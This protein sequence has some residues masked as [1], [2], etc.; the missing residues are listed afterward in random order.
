MK[1]LIPIYVI[2][3]RNADRRTRMRQ[4]F[5]HF[6]I[7]PIFTPEVTSEDPRLAKAPASSKRVW[8][9]MLQHMDSIQ[10]FYDCGDRL[11]HCII[12]EDDIHISNTFP[13]DMDELIPKFDEM[14]L[15]CLLLGCL[16]NFKL[17][18][19]TCLHREHFAIAGNTLKFNLHRYPGDTWGCQ[20]YMISRA[21]AKKM[22][23]LYTIDYALA[24]MDND[25]YSP[26]WTLTKG[27]N[28][29]MVYPMVA[30]E[31]GVNVSG[32]QSQIWFHRACFNTNFMAGKYI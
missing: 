32:D 9:V 18:M 15:D 28:R 11:S 19:N 16:L 25:K 2:N 24:N 29:A 22:I 10:N 5:N 17:D 27:G 4:R 23:D 21:Y 8:A 12:C 7:E 20:M 3:F 13:D 26:D 14:K 1:E 6:G 30:V 31:E